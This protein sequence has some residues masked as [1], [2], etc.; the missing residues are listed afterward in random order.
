MTAHGTTDEVKAQLD[1]FRADFDALRREV[2][3]VIV[4]LSEIVDDTLTALPTSRQ[5]VENRPTRPPRPSYFAVVRQ[6]VGRRQASRSERD[7]SWPDS[8]DRQD[9]RAK[10]FILQFAIMG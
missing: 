9:N 5:R 4:G 8:M 3:K 1:H 6:G 7:Q 10:E 2:G